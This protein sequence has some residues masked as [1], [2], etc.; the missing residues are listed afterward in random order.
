M[1]ATLSYEGDVIAEVTDII[2]SPALNDAAKTTSEA[3]DVLTL[4]LMEFSCKLNDSNASFEKLKAGLDRLNRPQK[5][6]ITDRQIYKT[7]RMRG[8][9]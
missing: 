6:K 7:M 9:R 2:V 8:I 3:F 4:G 1:T 5:P